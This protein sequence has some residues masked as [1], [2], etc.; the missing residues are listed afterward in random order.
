MRKNGILLEST[1]QQYYIESI[2]PKKLLVDLEYVEQIF[3]LQ[4]YKVYSSWHKRNHSSK[5]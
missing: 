3:D 4:G 2:L 1:P 5:F